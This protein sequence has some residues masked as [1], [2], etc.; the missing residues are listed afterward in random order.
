MGRVWAADDMRVG[1]RALRMERRRDRFARPLR[2]RA[3]VH[4]YAPTSRRAAG[5]LGVKA[6][7]EATM[8]TTTR[9]V[10]DG[11]ADGS[12]ATRRGISG[13]DG[14]AAA[15]PGSAQ[16]RQKRNERTRWE[17]NDS[18]RDENNGQQC[19]DRLRGDGQPT[20]STCAACLHDCLQNGASYL[21]VNDRRCGRLGP[22]CFHLPTRTTTAGLKSTRAVFVWAIAT[23]KGSTRVKDGKRY[24]GCRDERPPT[25]RAF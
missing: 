18:I 21:A 5:S 9:L 20:E 24:R 16:A 19:D 8:R 10:R 2:T 11:V 23:S 17:R 3:P 6:L 15:I 1:N 12:A 4:S 13:S 7:R 22:I 25:Y 14:N